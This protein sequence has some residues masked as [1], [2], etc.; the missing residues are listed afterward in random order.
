MTEITLT[1]PEPLTFL[2]AQERDSLL[3]AGL[4][5]AVRSRIER[6][7][8]EIGQAARQTTLFEAKY[9]MPFAQFESDLM[10]S[11][12]SWQAH[13]DYNDWFYWQSL[14]ADKQRLLDQLQLLD[15]FAR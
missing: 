7:K 11:L 6:L 14:L 1:V 5:Q 4:R 15:P 13:E 10:P 2:P 3:R 9:N 12:D 8:V